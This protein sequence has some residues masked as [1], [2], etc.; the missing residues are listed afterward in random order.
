MLLLTT[1]KQENKKTRKQNKP[2]N[3]NKTKGV[4]TRTN[5][6]AIETRKCRNPTKHER[7]QTHVTGN[8]QKALITRSCL[9]SVELARTK[10]YKSQKYLS[11]IVARPAETANR[12]SMK[13]SPTPGGTLRTKKSKQTPK[14]WH[15]SCM[16]PS[17]SAQRANKLKTVS[18]ERFI[19][20]DSKNIHQNKIWK[21]RPKTITFT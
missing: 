11:L 13:L 12:L 2:T 10:Q 19:E 7:T 4:E 17:F 20:S 16:S 6:K 8:R 9:S 5:R 14:N 21:V 15:D 18:T 3:S 1:R